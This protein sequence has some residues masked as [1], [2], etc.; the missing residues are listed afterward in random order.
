MTAR[1]SRTLT[2]TYLKV[3]SFVGTIPYAAMLAVACVFDDVCIS[4]ATIYITN[5][6]KVT[7]KSISSQPVLKANID[8][9]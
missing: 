8:P 7:N 5:T 9:T 1:E 4:L 2:N 6:I 3:A